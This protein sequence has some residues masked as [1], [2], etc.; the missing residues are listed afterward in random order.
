MDNRWYEQLPKIELHLHLEGAIPHEALWSLVQKYDGGISSNEALIGRFAYKDFAH[1]IET[2]LWKSEVNEAREFGIVGIGIGESEK[3]YPPGAFRSVFEKARRFGFYT[4]AHAGEAAGPESI[5]GTISD[6][7]VDRI[8][9][10]TKAEMDPTLLDHIVRKR[11]PIEMCP[12]SNVRTGS[13]ETYGAHPVRRYFDAENDILVDYELLDDYLQLRLLDLLI[14]TH[15]SYET[16][17]IKGTRQTVCDNMA[18]MVLD[19]FRLYT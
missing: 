9:H 17:E 14:D 7:Q 13:V 19:D 18:S 8:G 11:I 12:I 2:W 5:W 3:E 6:L 15:R 4:S 10:G 16:R 1:F